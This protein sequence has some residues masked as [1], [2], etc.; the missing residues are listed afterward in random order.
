LP[1]GYD[2]RWLKDG[3]IGQI[4]GGWG[5]NAIV[6]AQGGFPLNILTVSNGLQGLA[7]VGSNAA[8]GG[9]RPNLIGDPVIADATQRKTTLQ[10]FNTAAF[11][12]PPQYTFGNSPRTFSNLRGPGHFSTNMSVQ[13]NFKFTETMRLQ[14][15]VEGFNVFNRAN[16]TT[17][18]SILG[19]A[20]FGRLLAAED[21]R[22]MQFALK[23]YF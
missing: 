22:Q 18:V 21:A 6:Q 15:R 7:F 9:L 8:V 16:F 10:W 19:A 3:V 20:N 1:F 23:L 13:R 11:Q 4:V 5:L 17:P 12:A 14:F 2:R